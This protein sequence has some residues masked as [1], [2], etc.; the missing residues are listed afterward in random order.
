MQ[1]QTDDDDDGKELELKGKKPEG[2]LLR[3]ERKEGI[4]GAGGGHTLRVHLKFLL[5]FLCS[6]P[7]IYVALSIERET[8]LELELG[9]SSR[10]FPNHL[11][12]GRGPHLA[13]SLKVQNFCKSSKNSP[14]GHRF[15]YGYPSTHCRWE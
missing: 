2:S 4:G 15:K 10:S 7:L 14:D 8:E 13:S 9:I 11:L 1:S 6:L 5:H 3:E 12:V